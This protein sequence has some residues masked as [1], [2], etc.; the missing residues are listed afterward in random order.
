MAHDSAQNRTED[1][2]NSTED[3]L[4]DSR[5][6]IWVGQKKERTQEREEPCNK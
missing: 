2:V 3:T 6:E 1:K 4:R 5:S